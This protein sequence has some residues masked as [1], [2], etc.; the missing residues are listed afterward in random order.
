MLHAD[1]RMKLFN[2][3]L[4]LSGLILTAFPAVRNV[5]PE[6]KLAGFL[7]MLLVLAA[8]IF[9]RLDE[10]TKG[11]L[12]IAKDALRFLDAQWDISSGTEGIP[13]CLCLVERDAYTVG[14]NEAKWW[15]PA[16]PIHYTAK[17]SDRISD[18][19]FGGR[20]ARGVDVV[21]VR[22]WEAAKSGLRRAARCT[23][24]GVADVTLYS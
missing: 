4:I 14:K 18:G 13:H 7:P 9:W 10:R 1:Q 22:E 23:G 19:W 5:S 6:T 12:N 17:L 21:L 3:F 20:G 15:Y 24:P 2:F 11:L 8:F 16:I